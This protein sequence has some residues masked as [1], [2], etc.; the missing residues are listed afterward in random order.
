MTCVSTPRCGRPWVGSGAEIYGVFLRPLEATGLSYFIT[1]S[2]ASSAYGE[3]RYTQDLD[4]VLA[5]PESAV[6]SLSSTF[7]E[8]LFYV[9][10]EAVLLEEAGR[11]RG[12]HF[13][14]IH[15]ESGVRADVY[16]AGDDAL[17]AWAFDLRRRI[18][19][20]EDLSAWLAPPEYVIVRKLEYMA[21]GGG[22]R[23]L[24]DIRSMVDVLADGLDRRALERWIHQ[25]GLDEQWARVGQ[26]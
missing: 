26:A 19:L 15:H 16:L 8:S 17:H 1:G 25:K 13:N 14:L 3:P 24:R 7:D 20:E 4:L 22:E 23:H 21:E 9:P 5:L 18:E 6:R 2:V 12:G 10:P 11:V